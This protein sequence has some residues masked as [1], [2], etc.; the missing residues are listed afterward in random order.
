MMATGPTTDGDVGVLAG[1]GERGEIAEVLKGLRERFSS[2]G[3]VRWVETL[4]ARQARFCDEPPQLHPRILQHLQNSRRWPLYSHQ[5]R[6]IGSILE[7]QHTVVSS[8]TASG[9]TL[10]YNLPVL[11][12]ILRSEKAHA[13]YLFPTKALTQDQHRGLAELLD[14]LELRLETGIYDGDTD[15]VTRRRLR[16][17]GRVILTNPDMLHAAILPH[18]GFWAGLFANLRYVVIDELHSLRGIFGSHVA[19]VLRRL[20]RIARHHGSDPI[21]IA[22]SA[23]ISNPGEHAERLIGVPVEVISDD[24]APRGR[25]T[26][27][28]WN[29]P[30]FTRDDGTRFRKGPSSVAVRLLPELV[31]KGVKTICFG[32]TRN[33]V[34]LILRYIR[35]GA[36]GS[37]DRREVSERIEAYRGGYLPSERRRIESQLFSGE[38]G[39]VVSTNALEMGIDIGGLDGCLVVGWPGSVCSFLQQA[40]RAGRRLGDSLVILIGGQDPIDQ[41]FMRH[42][43]ALFERNPE[44]A[45]IEGENPYIRVRHLVCAAYEL[46]MSREEEDLFGEDLIPML[47]LLSEEGRLREDAGR[48]FHHL[49]GYPAAEFKL[50]TASD[51]NFTILELGSDRIVGELDYVAAMLSLY[52]GAVYIH[53]T[54]THIVEEMDWVNRIVKIRATPTGY[55]TQALCQKKVTCGE[56]WGRSEVEGALL[57]LLE[58]A[59]RTRVTGYKKVRF[60]TV[61]NVGFGQVDLPPIE[62]DSVSM[63]LDLSRETVLATEQFGPDFLQSG[64]H[65]MARLFRDLLAIRAMCDPGDLDTFIEGSVIHIYDLYPGGIGYSEV[66][67]ERYPELLDDTLEAVLDCPCDAGCPSCVLPG[68][69]RV[70]TYLEPSLVEYPY[71]KEATRFLL[72]RLLGLPDHVPCLEAVQVAIS[73]SPELPA[74]A[75]D[76][77]TERK[78]RKAIVGIGRGMRTSRARPDG[79]SRSR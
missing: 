3:D 64:M 53:R 73:P 42:P 1:G 4:E 36:A 63:E 74:P 43:E 69:S 19:N 70:E 75:L 79:E 24:G 9:K 32:R 61:E 52:E 41:Y 71:P 20:R 7:G 37:R 12:A 39:G 21:F 66:G 44:N 55:Y 48:W 6:A 76:E 2:A 26:V 51:E 59:V 34:E 11:D 40:G 8:S 10:C 58:V 62:L 46:P 54:E 31:A 14:A 35:E 47:S 78:V 50:R 27:V 13:L 30:I 22:A 60:H 23:T 77:R 33:T 56:E 68:Y 18:H 15:P 67:F 5:Q 38:L 17:S 16:K 25:K 29:P 28:L 45:V 65:G 49:D 57:R 72:H